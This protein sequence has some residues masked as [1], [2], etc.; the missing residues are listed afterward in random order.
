MRLKAIVGA[1][2]VDGTGRAPIDNA[3]VL[4]DG[5][6][7]S[8]VTSAH[9][10]V[11]PAEAEVIDAAGKYVIP[12]LMDANVHLCGPYLDI[13][14]EYEGRFVELVEEGAQLALRSGVTTVFDTWGPLAALVEARERI[15]RGAVVGSRLFVAGNIVGFD[16]PLS[17]DFFSPGQLLGPHTVARINSYFEHGI[18][19]KLLWMTPDGV[20]RQVREYLEGADVDFVKYAASGH[21]QFR[22]FLAFSEPTQRAIV[23]EARAAGL[24]VQAHTTTVESLRMAVEAG[25]DLLQHPDAT[26]PERIPEETLAAI[27]DRQVCAAVMPRTERH[28]AWVKN[29]GPEWL[30]TYITNDI[31]DE[32]LRRLIAV[33]AKLALSTDGM[34]SGPKIM[35][36]PVAGLMFNCADSPCTLGFSHFLWLEAVAERGMAPMDMLLA[37]TRN[38]AEAYGMADELGT[39]EPGKCADL[40]ILDADPLADVRNY[41]R[42]ADVMKDGTLVDRTRL[43]VQRLISVSADA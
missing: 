16:G 12:G 15:K 23:E 30:G 4:V 36:H 38:V 1:T 34:V 8:A 40:V 28:H 11:I 43:P 37:A 18:G 29:E 13:L 14:F 24:T 42:I 20:R 3:V 32:N 6:R 26:G 41:R 25:I 19:S 21:G 9:E 27:V 2:V 39:L 5:A 35:D 31:R 33:G 22:D 17:A 10:S 7:I